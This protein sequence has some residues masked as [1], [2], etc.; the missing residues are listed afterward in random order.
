MTTLALKTGEV[1][2]KEGDYL[3]PAGIHELESAI[4][5][6]TYRAR[7][8]PGTP[9]SV[10]LAVKRCALTAM[11]Y[12]ADTATLSN[13]GNSIHAPLCMDSW[14]AG[15]TRIGA[16]MR[17][18]NAVDL[19]RD[20]IERWLDGGP[21]YASGGFEGDEGLHAAEDEYLM[22]GAASL[23]GVGEYLA[24][25]GTTAW[26]GSYAPRLER[27][28]RLMRARDI[29]HDG[30]VE[31]RYRD[32]N[33]G[34]HGWST[35]WYDAISYGW[36]DALSNAL[37]YR[38][39]IL[40]D[41]M[42]PRLGRPELGSG[43]KDW[44]EK[45]RVNFLPAF[46]N[47]RTGWLGGWRSKDG[48]LHDYA[49]LAVNGAAVMSGVIPAHTGLSVLR[50][51]WN[52]ATRT[53]LPDPRL[54]LP[55]NLWPVPDDDMAEVMHGRPMGYYL[56]GGLTHSQSFR[57]VG[58]LYRVGMTAEADLLLDALCA[59]LA[60]GSAFGGCTSGV[61]WRYRDGGPCGYE[62]LLTDQFGILAVALDRYGARR[63]ESP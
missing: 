4:E 48:T 63:G 1:P 30:I 14:S 26:L 15:A 18:L 19:L 28:L 59:T 57:F 44:S 46:F 32:G 54:G 47:D 2:Q 50:A 9:V 31:S 6:F 5:P 34:G 60:D 51:L 25:S 16:L 42:L 23:L 12:R 58:A 29:D 45:L 40:L 13:N 33:S 52:E 39:L 20:S 36:K 35:N 8:L 41:D 49:F 10:A 61:D 22:T 56:N 27:Q 3:L 7:L 11:S 62:G 24:H 55:G 38:A 37:L 43:L 53:G 17:E 21:G